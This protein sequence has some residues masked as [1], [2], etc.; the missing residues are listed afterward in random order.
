MEGLPE[1]GICDLS[2]WERLLGPGLQ[3]IRSQAASQ[4]QP[5]VSTSAPYDLALGWQYGAV[6]SL[7]QMILALNCYA[8][9]WVVHAM[10]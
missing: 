4:A 6:P 10:S 8:H 3:P 1:T 9:H 7:A 5:A 2:V